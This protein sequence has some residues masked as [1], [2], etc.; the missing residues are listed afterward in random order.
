VQRVGGGGERLLQRVDA[1]ERHARWHRTRARWP[2][3]VARLISLPSD[4]PHRASI[5]SCSN[6]A[7]TKLD[8]IVC[9][10]THMHH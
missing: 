7:R 5:F 9:Y 6:K 4:R 10:P 3:R 2:G 1:E 8:W